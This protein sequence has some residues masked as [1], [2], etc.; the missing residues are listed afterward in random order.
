MAWPPSQPLT[1]SVVAS[2]SAT[3]RAGTLSGTT[4]SNTTTN[5]A[6]FAHRTDGL[7]WDSPTHYG[8][9]L[10]ASIGEALMSIALPS[11]AN[12]F[13]NG[14]T[15]NGPVGQYWAVNLRY[16]GEH[17]GFRVA[18]CCWLRS[19]QGG[20]ENV[21]RTL[22]SHSQMIHNYRLQ[23]IHPAPCSAVCSCRAP[24]SS[25]SVPT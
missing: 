23:R 17:H 12:N 22:G 7:R 10:G 8:F 1:L 13:Y 16:A 2:C 6:D 4:I 24:T 14:T 9:V 15:G 18:A 19:E 25:L 21:I 3:A 11:A 5:I 20:R